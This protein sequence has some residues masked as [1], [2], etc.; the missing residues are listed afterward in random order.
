MDMK[1]F[2]LLIV[3]LFSTFMIS[4]CGGKKSGTPE[5]DSDTVN[6]ADLVDKDKTLYGMW[7]SYSDEY[8]STHNR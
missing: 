3:C 4:G 7:R 1:Y 8:P 6:A 5:V 2:K